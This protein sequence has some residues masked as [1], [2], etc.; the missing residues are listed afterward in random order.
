MIKLEKVEEPDVL[1][2]NAAQWTTVVVS[3]IENGEEPTRTE[4]NR[5]NHRDIKQRLMQETNKK[6]AY[7]ESKFRHVTYGDIEHVVPK[8]DNPA[9]W[10]SWNNLTL[11]CDVCN[12]NKSNAP[13]DGESF[14][15]PYDGDPEEKF[16]HIG[17]TV[18]ARPG[19]DAA[20]LTERLLDLNRL[21]LVERRSERLSNLMRML[22]I[23]ERC[24]NDELRQALW[25]EFVSEAE[26][27]REYAALARSLIQTARQKFGLD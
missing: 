1:A 23:V 21:D 2:Q 25:E 13:V 5:Y 17:S 27:R 12:T 9:K 8:S 4:R 6:C 22:E 14:V 7:C 10:F 16:W 24:Q 15:D 18:W 20:A 11:A 26:S 19:C 3:K